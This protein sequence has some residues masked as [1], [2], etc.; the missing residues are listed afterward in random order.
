M[1][2]LRQLPRR[3]DNIPEQYTGIANCPMQPVGDDH[4]EDRE[5][6]LDCDLEFQDRQLNLGIPMIQGFAENHDRKGKH[7]DQAMQ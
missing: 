7:Q 3:D 1:A 4:Q 2:S 5:Q 6:L